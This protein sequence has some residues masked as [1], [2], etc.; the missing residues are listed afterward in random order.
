[1]IRK[2]MLLFS[3]VAALVVFAVPAG[4]QA[5]DWTTDGNVITAPTP[6]EFTGPLATPGA[7]VLGPC[8]V[9]IEATIDNSGTGGGV[10]NHF[11]TTTPGEGCPTSV[12]PLN[13]CRVEDVTNTTTTAEEDWPIAATGE[14]VV[15]I[16]NVSFT[17]H[18]SAPCQALGI[19]STF[20]TSGELE[21]TYNNES[22]CFELNESGPLGTTPNVGP[23]TVS[24]ELCNTTEHDI[25]LG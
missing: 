15:D 25:T 10:I 16:S 24:G 21:V 12:T 14:G 22:Q 23:I 20:T 6:V 18:L 8:T 1:M 5:E 3:A 13:N 17:N 11:E 19:P 7:I 4:A 9:H 2:K